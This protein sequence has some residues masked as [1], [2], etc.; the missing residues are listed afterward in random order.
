MYYSNH[1]LQSTKVLIIGGGD[2]GTMREVFQHN[3][4]RSV[5]M[6]ELDEQVVN[7]AKQFFPNLAVSF[8]YRE[9]L[10]QGGY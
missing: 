3:N 10:D 7:A 1:V 4:I 5:T 8:K 9:H 6:V 2:G